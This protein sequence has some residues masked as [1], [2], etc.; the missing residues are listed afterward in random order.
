M[1]PN[2]HKLLSR[3]EMVPKPLASNG[4]CFQQRPE[5]KNGGKSQR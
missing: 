3:W 1:A 5:D 4:G 2:T